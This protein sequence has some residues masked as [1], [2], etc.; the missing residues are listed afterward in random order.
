MKIT[1]F[2]DNVAPYRIGWADELG[3]TADVTFAYTKDK[4][5]ERNDAWLV[6]KS[7]HAKLVKLPAIVVKNKAITLAVI[8]YIKKNPT[9]VVIFDG[10]GILP[11]VFGILYCRMHKIKHFINIDGI[12]LPIKTTKRWI[13]KLLFNKY[14]YFMCGSDISKEW[15]ESFGIDSEKIIVHNFSSI[16]QKDIIEG[17]FTTEEKKVFKRKLGLDEERKCVIGVG[18]FLDW[19]QFDLLIRAFAPLDKD[20]QLVLIGEGEEKPKY[21]EIVRENLL[22]NVHILDFMSYSQLTEYYKAADVF[23][24]PS[25]GEI[26]G[27]VIN[28]AMSFGLPIITTDRCVSGR[29]L[30]LPGENGYRYTYNR[31]DELTECLEKVLGDIA[32]QE[33]MGK[34]SL[35]II[36]N[37]TIENIA[38]IH[39]LYLKDFEQ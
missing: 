30:V 37:Y 31:I 27:L 19:K 9:D 20:Y 2:S 33:K 38:R 22:Q 6:K 36:Q 18:R 21:E 17:V 16:Y 14:S 34:K 4:D 5:A 39:M 1:I 23:V 15:V 28:E 10:Y 29:A 32:I 25:D 8:K 12:T 26:W 35:E 11:N 3:K 24:L 7:K 13:K